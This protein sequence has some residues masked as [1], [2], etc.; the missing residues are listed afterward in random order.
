[1]FFGWDWLEGSSG[2]MHWA[3]E[4]KAYALLGIRAFD[5][6]ATDPSIGEPPNEARPARMTPCAT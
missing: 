6:A 1:M 3:R 4:E 2:G 5:G